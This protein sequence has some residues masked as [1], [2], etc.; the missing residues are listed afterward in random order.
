MEFN[1]VYL[2]ELLR[3]YSYVVARFAFTDV[4][5]DFSFYKPIHLKALIII[6]ANQIMLVS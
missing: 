1:M 6:R 4:H 3:S 5:T 2:K